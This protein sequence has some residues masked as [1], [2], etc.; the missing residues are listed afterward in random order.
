MRPG[1]L[2]FLRS[3]GSS[4]GTTIGVAAA[5]DAADESATAVRRTASEGDSIC[6][7]RTSTHLF[8]HAAPFVGCN[9]CG[10]SETVRPRWV[11][12]P[13]YEDRTTHFELDPS[14]QQFLTPDQQPALLPNISSFWPQQPSA[15]TPGAREDRLRC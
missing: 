5:V 10:S 9:F 6:P 1:W 7:L 8:P 4:C 15:G 3:T 12:N 14:G 13:E 2:A 11:A